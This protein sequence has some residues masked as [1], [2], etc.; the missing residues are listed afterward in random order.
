MASAVS[1]SRSGWFFFDR[2]NVIYLIGRYHQ[3]LVHENARLPG[4]LPIDK[5]SNIEEK[6]NYRPI[7]ALLVSSRLF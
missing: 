7:S 3:G 5:D 6:S 1:F 4:F 2:C